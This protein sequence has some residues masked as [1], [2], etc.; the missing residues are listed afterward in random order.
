MSGSQVIT[1]RNGHRLRVPT[2]A[3]MLMVTC[4]T[5][6]ERFEW[7]PTEPF[8]ARTDSPTV[9][10]D[11]TASP[12]LFSFATS[13]LS[14]DAFV[15]WLASWA[16][17]AHCTTDEPLH[18][19]ARLLLDRLLDACRVPRPSEYRSVRVRRQYKR[20]DVLVVVND[21]IAV[22]I[23]DKTN[24][25]DHSDQLKRYRLALC[26][27]FA[28]ARIAPVFLKTGDQC[29]L[30][31]PQ[32]AG[33]ACFLR[34]DLLDI[35]REGRESGVRNDIFEDFYRYLRG[36]QAAV[37]SYLQVPVT[38]WDSDPRRWVGFFAALR[39]R[40]GDGDWDRVN[41]PSGGFMGFWWHWN[42]N[43]YLQLEESKLCFKV[44]V[45]DPDP[46]VRKERWRE[47]HDALVANNRSF[48]LPL[49]KSARKMGTWMSVVVLTEDYRQTDAKGM[50]DIERT[51]ER[52]REAERL[53]DAAAEATGS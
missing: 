13:E 43:R 47:W 19:T 23:E 25:T 8:E 18:R 27:E 39:E 30:T 3:G 51:V 17:P 15:A 38:D 11:G 28:E 6:R 32:Q 16:D 1:C 29:D 2:N 36:I 49:K 9:A 14:Q 45:V 35:L 42:G 44:K 21:E 46:V 48:G 22:L 34:R 31:R 4:P 37:Q 12:S 20:I 5:C 52:L 41:N 26:D 10:T 24:T 33:Y 7:S 53:L 40:L 50:I